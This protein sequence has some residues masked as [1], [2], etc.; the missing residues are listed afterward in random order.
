MP[1]GP[2]VNVG[3][4]ECLD[5]TIPGTTA[6]YSCTING[7]ALNKENLGCSRAQTLMAEERLTAQSPP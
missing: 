5:V 4:K 6:G 1:G 2:F 3:G 7:P